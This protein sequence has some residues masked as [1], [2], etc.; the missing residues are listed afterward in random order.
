MEGVR[1][2]EGD[3]DRIRAMPNRR[4]DVGPSENCGI[5]RSDKRNRVGGTDWDRDRTEFK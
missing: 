5:G 3:S 4:L 1:R 2:R